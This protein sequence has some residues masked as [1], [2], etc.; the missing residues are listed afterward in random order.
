MADQK[1]NQMQRSQQNQMQNQGNGNS[2]NQPSTFA[3]QGIIYDAWG[4]PTG[5][6]YEEWSLEGPFSG[7]G[8]KGYQRSDERIMEDVCDRLTQHGQLDASN[9]QVE[10]NNGE[11]T[12]KG[13]VDSRWAKRTAED[14]ADSV[15]GVKDVHNQLR[16]AQS[17]Q[18]MQDQQQQQPQAQS[19]SQKK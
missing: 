3:R 2:Q 8:P 10:V 15:N 1:Q 12:L 7:K 4:Q 14:T 5:V 19:Q 13:T 9:V 17:D 18:G 11:V 6:Y 16:I